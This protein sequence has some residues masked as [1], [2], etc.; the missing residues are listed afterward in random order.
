MREQTTM[1]GGQLEVA[2][3]M[4]DE[5]W[6]D[7][8]TK[9]CTNEMRLN[10]LRYATR[11]TQY[12]ARVG[13]QPDSDYARTTVQDVITDT[14][15]G[16]LKWE[17]AVKPLLQHVLDSIRYRTRDDR[18]RAARYREHRIDAFD[19]S[20]ET[21]DTR[22]AYEASLV[23]ERGVRSA[24]EEVAHGELLTQLRAAAADDK[25][26]IAFIDAVLDGARTRNEIMEIAKLSF[27][28]YRTARSRLQRIMQNLGSTELV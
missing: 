5:A 9:Q 7:A 19:T 15:L 26:L 6:L 23:I 10:A 8:F 22:S 1:A 13:G 16:T 21:A 20:T 27:K 4:P 24:H 28:A 14:M 18:K 3:F 25:T 2:P 12:I 17:P 11:R